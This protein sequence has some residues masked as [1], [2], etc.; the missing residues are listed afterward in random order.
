[1]SRKSKKT[2]IIV[3]IVIIIITVVIAGI[4]VYE[5]TNNGSNATGN[6]SLQPSQKRSFF[7][8]SEPAR[9]LRKQYIAALYIEG[10]IEDANKTYN[11]E[12]LLT[13]INSLKYDENNKA[14]L[15]YINSPGGGVY[16]SDEVYLALCDY[17]K[18]G[19][20]VYAYMGPLAASGGYYIACAADRIYANRNTLTGSIGVIAGSSIDATEL[21]KKI[22]IKSE[23]ITAG[24]NKNMFNYNSPLTDEQR[25]IM[26][27]VA[28]EAYEQFTGIVAESRHMKS[29]DVKKLADGRIYTAAQA[30]K[31]GLIDCIGSW[32]DAVS[33]ISEQLINTK[34][35]VITYRYEKNE[36]VFDIL[37]G[38]ATR[39]TGSM[40]LSRL[41]IP[42]AIADEIQPDIPYPAYIYKR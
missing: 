11:Q 3:F 10:T 17:K 37:S 14:I 27:A 5:S 16:Q 24:K 26:Q 30:Q 1:M 36:S 28:D 6:P 19:K 35:K 25:A 40:T 13:N 2:G 31:N 29:A 34:I 21:L 8:D 12:W 20:L 41:G 38:A 7:K 39:L 4:G 33:T 32:D 23:T 18:T 42:E 9:M 15:L 22:G